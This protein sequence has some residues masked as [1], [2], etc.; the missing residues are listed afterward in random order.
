MIG[1]DIDSYCSQASGY[2]EAVGSHL[3]LS[4]CA[5]GLVISCLATLSMGS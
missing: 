1:A 4:E 3:D 2:S 5:R